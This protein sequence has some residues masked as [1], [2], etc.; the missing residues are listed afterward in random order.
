MT[1]ASSTNHF[2]KETMKFYPFCDGTI[3]TYGPVAERIKV[4]ISFYRDDWNRSTFYQSCAIFLCRVNAPLIV[5]SSVRTT[6]PF[7]TYIPWVYC[8]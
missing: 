3:G 4:H 2:C 1:E 6:S 7:P 8:K 5:Q